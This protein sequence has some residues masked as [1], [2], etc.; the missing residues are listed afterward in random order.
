MAQT[1]EDKG[2]RNYL[3]LTRR[4]RKIKMKPKIV[5]KPK[6]KEISRTL[7]EVSG[8]TIKIQTSKGR[9]LLLC[10]CDNAS[11]FGNNQ[12]CSHIERVIEYI[13]L[14]PIKK[15]VDKLIKDYER[16]QNI[17]KIEPYAFVND[18]KNLKR[19]LLK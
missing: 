8:H 6:V 2:E 14:K 13:K 18:L 19:S 7:F 3:L 16:F 12:F 10:N 17:G 4:R 15:A 9:R 11:F 5:N 1:I